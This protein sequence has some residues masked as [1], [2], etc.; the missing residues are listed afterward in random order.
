[1]IETFVFHTKKVR[2]DCGETMKAQ[3][4]RIIKGKFFKFIERA[5]DIAIV[6][7]SLIVYAILSYYVTTGEIPNIFE[8][9][10][11]T[12]QAAMSY[13]LYIIVVIVFFRIYNPSIFDKKYLSVMKSIVLSLFM[14]NIILVLITFVTGSDMMF[15][16]MGAFGVLFIQLI[17]FAIFKFL[18]H[19]YFAKL[20]LSRSIIVGTKVDADELAKDFYEDNEHNKLLT[21]IIY[22]KD[23][24]LPENILQFLCET[25]SIY[26][27]PSISDKNRQMLLQYGIAHY[28]KDVHLIPR[29]YEISL[30]NS[31]DENIDDTLVLHIPM[32]R[33][34]PEQ[35]FLKRM[36]DLIVSSV[37]LIVLSPLFLV[38]AILIKLEDKGP[39]FY[40]QERFKRNN[41][42]FMVYKFRSMKVNQTADQINKRPDKNDNRITKVGKFIRMTRIDELPQLINV[43]RSDMSMVG[44]RPLIKE[45]IDEAIREIP[46]F[47]YRTNV[48]PGLTGLAQVKGKYDTKAR[49]KIRY[50]LLYVKRASFFYD[51]K[52]LI[53]TIKVIFSKGSVIQAHDMTLEDMFKLKNIEHTV[54][55]AYIEIHN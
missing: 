52:I 35:R 55:D 46:E 14:A 45:E 37:L 49:E 20:D 54:H 39:V 8:K 3:I 16:A 53:L 33:M 21:H 50:D 32:M 48:K 47:Y 28:A 18:S 24:K 41:E 44:P 1:M 36:F 38:I 19:K 17:L 4:K 34:T 51:M 43:F 22:E 42:P 6:F 7:G 29:T 23:G 15:S 26:I 10:V 30:L 13:A 27:T 9:L 2:I 5:L 31:N 40:R 25:D 12:L 11:E